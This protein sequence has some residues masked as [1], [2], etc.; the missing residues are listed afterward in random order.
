MTEQ[1]VNLVQTGLAAAISSGATSLT[2]NSATGMPSTGNFRILIDSEIFIVTAVSGTT[3]TVTPGAE[4]STTTSH[5]SGAIV[6]AVLTAGALASAFGLVLA[7]SAVQVAHTGDTNLTTLAS[8]TIPANAMGA[9]GRVRITYTGGASGTN[10]K[11]WFISFGGTV[12]LGVQTTTNTSMRTQ[13]EIANRNAT[14]SQVGNASNQASWGSST[15][16]VVTAS[17]DTTSPVTILLQGVL[18]NSSE[19]ITLESYLVELFYRA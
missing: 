15:Q 2:V 11:E 4:G 16:G 9:N 3:L 7:Q 13:T 14:N 8:I 10:S 1:L 18:G 17:V 6:T 5:I 19:T 12:L